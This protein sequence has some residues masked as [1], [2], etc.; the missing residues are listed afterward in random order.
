MAALLGAALLVT[1]NGPGGIYVRLSPL[2]NPAPST[3][4]GLA[5]AC[6]ASGDPLGVAVA[7]GAADGGCASSAANCT[8]LAPVA[9]GAA[10]TATGGALAEAARGGS[11]CA[12]TSC[13]ACAATEPD[14]LV[15]G[16]SSIPFAAATEE[17]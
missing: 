15:R 17:A 2:L 14:A 10:L 8:P 1:E 11:A 6:A 16:D 3:S 4:E 7:D 5:A 13:A 9:A 12:A